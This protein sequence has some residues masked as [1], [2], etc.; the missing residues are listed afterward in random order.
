M[1]SCDHEMQRRKD[2]GNDPREGIVAAHQTEKGFFFLRED[3][4]MD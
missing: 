3:G 2:I 1:E 4:S